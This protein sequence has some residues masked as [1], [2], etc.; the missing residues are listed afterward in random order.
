[1][2]P[3]GGVSAL[4]PDA[5]LTWLQDRGHRVELGHRVRNLRVA[6]GTWFV[7]DEPFD[8]VVL[9]CS[10]AEAARLSNP[11]APRWAAIAAALT[12]EAIAT[13]YLHRGATALPCPIVALRSTAQAPA[14]FALDLD[15]LGVAARTVAFVVSGARD[16]V[17]RGTGRLSAAVQAQA[18]S[19]LP[20][21]F[22]AAS[23][24]LLHTSVERRATFACTAGLARPP[25]E[26]APGLVAAGDYIAG[27]YPATLEGAVRSG[28]LAA[29]A[30]CTGSASSS[31]TGSLDNASDCTPTMRKLVP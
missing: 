10:A 5:A 13:I 27:P 22:A 28:V 23:P 17:D 26:I 18:H 6:A 4:F 16:W 1:M 20:A 29:R 9:A 11:I 31:S 2:L 25:A 8:A 12:Y 21:Q 3:R 7:D 19:A 24:P 14:Q 15:Y 30:A